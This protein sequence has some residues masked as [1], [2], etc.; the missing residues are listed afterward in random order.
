MPDARSLLLGGCLLAALLATG[1]ASARPVALTCAPVRDRYAAGEPVSV[2]VTYRNTG[3][4]PVEIS[5]LSVPWKF[6]YGIRFRS[7]GG[8][9]LEE[10][11]PVVDPGVEDPTRI[12]PGAEASGEVDLRRYL[13]DAKGRTIDALPGTHTITGRAK[14]FLTIDGRRDELQAGCGPMRVTVAPR[15]ATADDAR[16]IAEAAGDAAGY[17]RAKYRVRSIEQVKDAGSFQG[18]WAVFFEHV[19]PAP[20]GGHFTVYVN[21]ADG[22]AQLFH[23]E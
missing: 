21:P 7:S 23:G 14:V 12:E 6:H 19:P 17:S 11:L 10:A 3:E 4:R 5:L 9:G 22:K 20:P 8:D 15:V 2:R 1:C 13:A 18:M 16:R